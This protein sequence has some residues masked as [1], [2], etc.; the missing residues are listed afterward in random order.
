MRAAQMTEYRKPLEVVEIPDP[1]CGESDVVIKVTAS[2]ICRT[3]WHLW[4]GDW[5][6]VP[7]FSGET[8]STWQAPLPH[9]MG[10]EIAGTIVEAGPSVRKLSVG[11][12]VVVPWHLACGSCGSC[13]RAF[14]NTCEQ[15]SMAGYGGYTGAYA[16]YVAIRQADINVIPIA[17]SVSQLDAF[18]LGCRYMAAYGAVVDK[19]QLLAGETL[20]VVGAGAL[21]LSAVQIGKA[22]GAYVVAVDPLESKLARATE[23]GADVVL[24]ASRPDAA[25]AIL[26]LTGGGAHVSVDTIARPESLL[27]ACMGTRRQGRVVE[28]GYTTQPNNGALPIPMDLVGLLELRLHGSGAGYNHRDFRQLVTLVERGALKPS[29]L[30][31]AQVGLHGITGVLQAMDTF[32]N[33]GY[34]VVT[35]F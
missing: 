32:H 23:E 19:G 27:T 30:V 1:Q 16:E 2:G 20:L 10:H 17:A 21:G 9:V 24:D 18:G 14:T 7:R 28:A 5:A 6:W 31:S 11:D 22:A 3:D 29:R 34:Q 26:E 4:N 12:S 35:T 33:V 15:V 13:Q 8:V 25:M